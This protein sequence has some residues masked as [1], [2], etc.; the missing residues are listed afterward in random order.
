MGNY[1][2][3][4]IL[5]IMALSSCIQPPIVADTK[6]EMLAFITAPHATLCDCKEDKIIY[7]W[8]QPLALWIPLPL[9]EPLNPK[10]ANYNILLSDV[11]KLIPCTKATQ[12]VLGIPNDATLNFPIGS[13]IK[14]LQGGAGQ[15]AFAPVSPCVLISLLNRNKTL[16]TG[17]RAY[18]QKVAVNI[19][20]LWCDITV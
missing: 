8:D 10:T 12:F 11:N 14:F 5:I 2:T 18:L 3:C 17:A 13:T 1:R 6:A 4:L 19:W 9:F 15:I 7:K 16:G 20:N